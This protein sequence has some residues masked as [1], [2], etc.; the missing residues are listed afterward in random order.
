M[1]EPL[2]RAVRAAVAG[3]TGVVRAGDQILCGCSGGPDSTALLLALASLEG[4]LGFTLRALYVDHG[5]RPAAQAEAA[6]VQRLCAE[7]DVPAEV[8][9]VRLV[10]GESLQH[11]ARRARYAALQE[12]ARRH[13][14][15]LV[16]VGHTRS[17]QAET[18]LMRLLGGA[19]LRGLG[20]MAPLRPLEE[21]S[22]APLLLR[23]LLQVDRG[24]VLAFLEAAGLGEAPAQDP[25][26]GDPRFLRSRLRAGVVPLLRRERPDLERHLGELAE[27]LRADAD[28]LDALGAEAHGRL[29]GG[30]ELDAAGLLALPRALQARVL[31]RAYGPLSRRHV[32]AILALCHSRSGS[33]RADLPGR[34]IERRY[35]RLLPVPPSAE[36]AEGPEGPGSAPALTPAR[37]VVEIRGPG[38]YSLGGT[39]VR[40]EALGLGDVM[41]GAPILG[42]RRVLFSGEAALRHPRPGDRLRLPAGHRK[43]SDLLV[44]AKVPRALRPGAVLLCQGERVLWLAG[45]RAAAAGPALAADGGADAGSNAGPLWLAELLDA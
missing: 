23:P 9:R 28:C 31:Q 15:R 7:L 34:A 41:G 11:A 44:D 30:V 1:A 19:G 13:G 10:P 22:S 39:T 36:A 4:E 16:A 25:S 33:Q 2:L 18:L 29:G 43:V 40:V 37:P 6:A 14:A 32:E 21:G 42:P 17:D 12:A 5:L 8:T 26:N 20:A 3:P 24:D 38:L 35:G 27:Q 45:V